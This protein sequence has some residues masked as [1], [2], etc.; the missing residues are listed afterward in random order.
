M[1]FL[2]PPHHHKNTRQVA[3]E[4]PTIVCAL[5]WYHIFHNQYAQEGENG[6]WHIRMDTEMHGSFMRL[7]HFAL[8]VGRYWIK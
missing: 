7:G 2:R 1:S 5:G 4:S 6:E 8:G 3:V